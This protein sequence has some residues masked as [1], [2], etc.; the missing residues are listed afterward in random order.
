MPKR[1]MIRCP[2]CKGTIEFNLDTLKVE[3]HW[4]G[5]AEGAAHEDFG[6]L[7]EKAAKRA[8]QGLPDIAA[9]LEEQQRRRDEEFERAKRKL[10]EEDA[11]GAPPAPTA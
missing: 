7:I 11:S 4:A 6:A 3:R 8:G 5:K 2:Q 9:A 10:Q 1:V